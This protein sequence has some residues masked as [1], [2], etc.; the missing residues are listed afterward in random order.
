MLEKIEFIQDEN[1]FLKNI[2]DWN[3]SIAIKLAENEGINLNKAHW[4]IIH[5]VRNFYIQ[6]N[7]VPNMRIIVR[8]IA[9]THGGKKANSRYL[10]RLFSKSPIKQISK[11]AGLP[12]PGICI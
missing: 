5:L 11:I 12:N 2:Y 8:M 6:F 1:G 4:E 7:T 9:E 3:E 10:F